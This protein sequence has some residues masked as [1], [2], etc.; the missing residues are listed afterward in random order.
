MLYRLALLEDIALDGVLGLLSYLLK[1]HGLVNII[2]GFEN[3]DNT[4]TVHYIVSPYLLDALT[5]IID[6]ATS[7]HGI[8]KRFFKGACLDV[9]VIIILNKLDLIYLHFNHFYSFNAFANLIHSLYNTT[10]EERVAFIL[11]MFG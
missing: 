10:I 9:F 5:T 8:T 7:M 3:K 11:H 1:V 4:P 6:L 2:F